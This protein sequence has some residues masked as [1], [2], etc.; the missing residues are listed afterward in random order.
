MEDCLER[1][2]GLEILQSNNLVIAKNVQTA[3]PQEYH[4]SLRKSI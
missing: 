4:K 1:L 3:L 2:I